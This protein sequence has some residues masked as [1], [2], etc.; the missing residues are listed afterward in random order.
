MERVGNVGHQI[1]RYN[2]QRR[3]AL[4]ADVQASRFNVHVRYVSRLD[5]VRSHA[6]CKVCAVRVQAG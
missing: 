1:A 4:H 6:E 5:D 3:W 2:Q